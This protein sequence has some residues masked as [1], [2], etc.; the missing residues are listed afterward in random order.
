MHIGI[1]YSDDIFFP[2]FSAY[3]RLCF[4]IQISSKANKRRVE[5][6]NSKCLERKIC[7][8]FKVY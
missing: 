5:F 1:V 7:D 2:G 8:S 6:E 4:S 3:Q